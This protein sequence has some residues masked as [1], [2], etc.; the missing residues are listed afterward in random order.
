MSFF[1]INVILFT[2]ISFFTHHFSKY[3][4]FLHKCH[5]KRAR[6]WAK[7]GA[8][9]TSFQFEIMQLSVNIH[10]LIY[11]LENDELNILMKILGLQ[12]DKF[13]FS[14]SLMDCASI[15]LE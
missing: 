2:Q 7:K 6:C 8:P 9:L 15:P 14:D 1:K 5:F 4:S 12:Y 11:N 10:I 13:L 3:M